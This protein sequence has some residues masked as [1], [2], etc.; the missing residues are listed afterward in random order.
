MKLNQLIDRGNH[1]MI[2]ISGIRGTIPEGLDPL[3]IVYFAR[4]FAEITGRKIVIGCD[5][6]PTGPM[7]RDLLTGTLLA[8]GKEVLDIGLAPTPTVKA[9]VFQQKADAGVVIS[10][11]HNPL[12]WN[13]FKFITRNGFFF[14]RKLFD[15]WHAALRSNAFPAVN[16]RRIG[17]LRQLDAIGDHIDAVLTAIPNVAAIRRQRYRVV[18]DGVGGAGREALPRL[19]EELGCHVVRLF[20]E[21]SPGKFPRP[22]EPTPAA[23][24]KFGSLVQKERAAVGFALDPDADRLVCGSPTTGA[25][26]EEYTLPLALL[27]MAPGLAQNSKKWRRP[28]TI[29][30][31]LSTADLCAHVAEQIGARVVRSAVGEA[32]VVGMMR[33]EKAVFGGEGNGGVIHPLLPSFGRDS[34]AGAALI[35]SAM[36]AGKA[37]NVDQLMRQLP[38]LHMHKTKYP[39]GKTDRDK[40]FKRVERAFAPAAIDRR[41]GLHLT[42][43]DGSWI[44]LRASNTEPIF[45]VIVQAPSRA[46][47]KAIIQQVEEQLGS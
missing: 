27:G 38:A 20:C 44:H 46:R 28:P 8:A 2:S 19:L 34:L 12:E 47:L 42:L 1:L 32:N 6:R 25:I 5:N 30:V 29:V 15:R 9:A 33:S 10:A 22:P 40:L 36:D 3:N 4:A 23:L 35:L 37:M 18:V 13:G 11:S 39:T 24:R 41:D 26:H 14:D 17:T 31:N 45:R 43:A 7:L 16:Y 21:E